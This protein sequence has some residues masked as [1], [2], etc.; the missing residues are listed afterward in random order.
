M[1][2]I[3]TRQSLT[4]SNH[5]HSTEQSMSMKVGD[6]S[7][8]GKCRLS[9]GCRVVEVPLFRNSTNPVGVLLMTV[10]SAV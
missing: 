6:Q 7:V 10:C 9:G 2:S 5:C 1:P 8:N 4:H 3:I